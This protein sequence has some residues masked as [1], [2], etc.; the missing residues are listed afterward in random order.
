VVTGFGRSAAA[1]PSPISA[2]GGTVTT[3]AGKTIHTFTA[4][5]TFEVTSG[6]DDVE[7]LVVGHF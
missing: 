5:G 6:S 4:S 1:G 2:T 3:A 7:Y